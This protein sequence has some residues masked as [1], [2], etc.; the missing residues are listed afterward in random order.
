MQSFSVQLSLQVGQAGQRAKGTQET[1]LR[2]SINS[3]VA[4]KQKESKQ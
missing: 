1:T 3:T 2:L 4:I